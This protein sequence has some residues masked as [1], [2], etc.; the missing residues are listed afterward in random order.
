MI[1]ILELRSNL[2]WFGI[3]LDSIRLRIIIFW[4]FLE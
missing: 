1:L 3:L 2:L 4:I